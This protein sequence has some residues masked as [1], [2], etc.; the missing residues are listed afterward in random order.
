[1]TALVVSETVQRGVRAGLVV[2]ITPILTDGP[3]FA[4]TA[5]GLGQLTGLDT[6]MGVLSLGGAAFLAWLGWQTARAPAPDLSA[7][8]ASST[9]GVLRRSVATNVLNPHP[10]LFWIALGTP[11]TLRAWESGLPVAVGFVATF[12]AGLVGVKMCLALFL[13]RMRAWF[14]SKAYRAVMVV[15]GVALGGMAVWLAV[16]GATRLGA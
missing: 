13:G 12:F 14:A 9:K 11:T 16:D 6:W 3:V 4:I 7:S 2:S 8:G 1:M 10:W 5:L 15:L